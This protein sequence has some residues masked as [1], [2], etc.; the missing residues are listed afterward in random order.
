MESYFAFLDSGEIRI[1]GTRVGIEI[2]LR[3]Y[4]EGVAPEEIVLRYPTLS[5]EQVRAAILYYLRHG[6]EINQYLKDTWEQGETAWQEQQR[7]SSEF[8]Q[9]LRKRIEIHP[10]G[11]PEQS[12]TLGGLISVR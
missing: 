10:Q 1:R 2:V 6:D 12:R 3:D 9:T 11:L 4:L 5:L 7:T 8:V